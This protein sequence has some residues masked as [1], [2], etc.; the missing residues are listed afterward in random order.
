MTTRVR[1]FVFTLNNYTDFDV[2]Y[3]KQCESFNYIVFGYEVG[4][5]G[6]PHLQGYAQLHKQTSFKK[7]G[8]MLKWHIEKV[9]S[10]PIKCVDYCKKDGK[11]Y[12]KGKP[13][14]F[15]IDWIKPTPEQHYK[16]YKQWVKDNNI[17]SYKAPWEAEMEKAEI[18]HGRFV[19]DMTVKE[20]IDYFTN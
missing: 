20:F 7:V 3:L 2:Q 15:K 5:S 19:A 6:T 8:S 9:K 16:M 4:A 17:K 18:M 12:E 11:Y 10:T 13:R 1:H 14:G